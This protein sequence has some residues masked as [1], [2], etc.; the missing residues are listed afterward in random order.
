MLEHRAGL[1]AEHRAV[2]A[3][4]AH[5]LHE[6]VEVDARAPR[7]TTSAWASVLAF[8]AATAL[9]MSLTVCP[10]PSLADVEDQLPIASNSGLARS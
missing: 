6:R 5:D 3:A 8:A 7:P 9:L 1:Q 2:A 10:W 4:G